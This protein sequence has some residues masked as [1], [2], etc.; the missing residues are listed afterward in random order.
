MQVILTTCTANKRADPGPIPAGARYVGA[1]VDA[2]ASRAAR[3]GW[4]LLFLSGAHGVVGAADPLEW[5]DHALRPDEVDGLIP[6]AAQQLRERGV[7]EIVAL[8][9]PR[10]TA[11]WAPYWAVLEGAASLA[12]IS[13]TVTLVDAAGAAASAS[14][15]GS[16]AP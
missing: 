6:R 7:S 16:T 12:G 2:A 4:P 1:R 5:Y 11:G 10:E 13:C 9:A 3:R 14:A 15:A 8:L